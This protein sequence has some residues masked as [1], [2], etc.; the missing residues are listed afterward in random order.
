VSRLLLFTYFV[1]AGLLL[2]VVPWTAF[3]ERNPIVAGW[4]VVG[5]LLRNFY[6]RG[7]V[8]GLGVICLWAA[9]TEL[10][11][12]LARRGEGTPGGQPSG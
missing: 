8:S 12:L 5:D 2:L 10:A 1:E 6:V 3:W 11:L 9:L 4:P 7:A